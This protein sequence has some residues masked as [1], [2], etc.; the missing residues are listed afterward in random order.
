[1]DAVVAT[2]E[3]FF[4]SF[5]SF[6]PSLIGALVLLLVGWL[7]GNIVGKIVKEVLLRLKA[8]DLIF[9][10]KRQIFKISSVVSILCSWAIYLLFIQAA[11]DVLGIIVLKEAV[12]Q[13][14]AFIPGLIKAVVIG[15]VGYAIAEYVRENVERSKV[16][17]SKLVAKL[18]F[19]LII[20]IAIATALP[21][22]GID[23]TLINAIL[24]V[25]VASFGLGFAIALGLGLKDTVA[26]LAKKGFK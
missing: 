15:L 3:N 10:G 12:G 11:V 16:P 13:I 21:L 22:V 19:F 1:M 18:L 20:Y 2:L 5:L 17:Y 6:L 24:I 7:L 8:D 4:R 26:K 9:R 25:I 23:T 14:V